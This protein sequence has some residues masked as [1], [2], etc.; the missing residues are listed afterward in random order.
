MQWLQVIGS[1]ATIPELVFTASD[2]SGFDGTNIN[3]GTS[4]I[5][6]EPTDGDRLVIV[7]LTCDLLFVTPFVRINGNTAGD[8][9]DFVAGVVNAGSR[10]TGIYSKVVNS[11]TT[12]NFRV[13]ASNTIFATSIGVYAAYGLDSTTATDTDTDSSGAV[14]VTTS[15][16]SIAVMAMY[17]SVGDTSGYTT[18]TQDYFLN[19]EGMRSTSASGSELSAGTL[20]ENPTN[21]ERSR[22]LATWR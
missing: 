4:A 15:A 7:A 22:T 19:V 13:V 9:M 3:L 1:Y 17:S 18:L 12:A 8:N 10:F 14:S 11:G 5:G 20:T 6:A 16:N 2:G 21:A